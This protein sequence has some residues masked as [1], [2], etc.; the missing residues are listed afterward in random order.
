MISAKNVSRCRDA[1]TGLA[2]NLWNVN[3]KKDGKGF[4]ARYVSV[5]RKKMTA[6][7]FTNTDV[8]LQPYVPR[9]VTGTAGTAAN[10]TNAGT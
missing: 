6:I 9:V 7:M 4:Y 5:K 10:R 1:C 3:A 8:L 2:P